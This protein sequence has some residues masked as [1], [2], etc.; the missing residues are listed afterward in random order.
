MEDTEIVFKPNGDGWLCFLHPFSTTVKKFKWEIDNRCLMQIKGTT[1]TLHYDIVEG[2]ELSLENYYDKPSDMIFR[3]L[4][5][6]I[7]IEFTP[8]GNNEVITFSEP[9][10]LSDNRFTLVHRDITRLEPPSFV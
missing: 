4:K 3:D 9:L 2:D 5:V 1:S 7:N 6:E 10:F 8:R